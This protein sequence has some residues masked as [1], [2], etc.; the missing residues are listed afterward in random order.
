MIR[1][2]KKRVSINIIATEYWVLDELEFSE[3]ESM[4]IYT[5]TR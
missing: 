3:I 5:V 2:I 1:L 4:Y